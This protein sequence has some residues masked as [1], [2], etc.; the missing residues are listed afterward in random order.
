M[1]FESVAVFYTS[2]FLMHIHLQ[3]LLSLEV[4][5]RGRK[6]MW[7]KWHLKIRFPV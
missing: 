2:N 4:R 5:N 6:G 1:T 3:I 7:R